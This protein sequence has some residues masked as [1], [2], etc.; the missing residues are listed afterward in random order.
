VC[1]NRNWF[2]IFEKIDG[3]SVVMGDDRPSNM[4][5]IG[6]IQIKMF[7]E[8]IREL[9]EVRYVPQL[10]RNL[11][12]VSALKTLVLEVSIKD[13]VL[14]MTKCSMVVL[15]GVSRN[16]LYY[17][18]GSTVIVQVATSTDSDDDSIR[19]WHMRLGHR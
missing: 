15:K 9:K 6:I 12:S 14:K 19:L 4:E 10:K 1:P 18:K 11:I 8:M 3:F 17:L 13:G 2:S 16:N 5:G 7:D